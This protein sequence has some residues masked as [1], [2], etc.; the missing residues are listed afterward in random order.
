MLSIRTY[1][2]FFG[3]APVVVLSSIVL[4]FAVYG[5]SGGKEE[6]EMESAGVEAQSS[7][8]PGKDHFDRGVKFSLM[9]QYEEAISEYKDSLKYNPDSAETYNNLGF[10]YMD[11]GDLD[12][13]IENQKK[14][15]ELKPDLANG[16]YGLALALEK[17]GEK[18]EALKNWKK[19]LELSTP[20][21][22]WWNKAKEHTDRLEKELK[23]NTE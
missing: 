14:A 2:R 13:A 21:T 7:G 1:L 3:P 22:R 16:Y 11:K 20:H 19:Y 15:V 18:E 12:L 17:K 10:A 6:P 5:C 9:G 4:L 8:D 23:K